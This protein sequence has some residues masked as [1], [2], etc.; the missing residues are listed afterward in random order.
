MTVL[1]GNVYNTTSGNVFVVERIDGPKAY[2]RNIRTNAKSEVAL[3]TIL[4]HFTL[5]GTPYNEPED[6]SG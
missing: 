6:K 4:N 5:I 1:V 3:Y 2:I